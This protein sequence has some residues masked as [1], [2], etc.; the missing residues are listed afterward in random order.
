[1]KRQKWIQDQ[2]EQHITFTLQVTSQGFK[3][4][5]WGMVKGGNYVQAINASLVR[6]ETSKC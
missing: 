5:G 3:Q 1:M 6:W 2:I 4:V